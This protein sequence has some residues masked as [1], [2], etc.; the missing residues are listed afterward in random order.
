MIKVE[1][2][3][4]VGVEAEIR[5]GLEVE[6]EVDLGE[7]VVIV[8]DL[9]V[10][11]KRFEDGDEDVDKVKAKVKGDMETHQDLYL[12]GVLGE[13]MDVAMY[14]MMDK[15]KRTNQVV[16]VV[17]A[18]VVQQQDDLLIFGESCNLNLIHTT[19]VLKST[20][21]ITATYT[22]QPTT[23][24]RSKKLSLYVLKHVGKLMQ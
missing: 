11:F 8:V 22:E 13:G 24:T 4:G 15:I 3:V 21:F 14:S 9:E 7:A 12:V 6:L 18:A 2:V 20:D 17:V 23:T 16:V 19:I 1:V 5:V 10:D